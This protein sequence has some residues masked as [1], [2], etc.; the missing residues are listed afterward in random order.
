[1]PTNVLAVTGACFLTPRAAFEHVGGLSLTFPLNYNDID[2]CLKL[3][4]LGYR[5]V[6]TPEVRLFH[7]ESSSRVSGPVAKEELKALR[8]RWGSLLRRD[9]FYNPN[10]YAGTA[11]CLARVLPCER[12]LPSERFVS[13]VPD[14]LAET[15]AGSLTEGSPAA[16][17]KV[18][19]SDPKVPL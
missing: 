16:G 2:F 14:H 4:N 8:S 1:V 7:F 18:L 3:H 15:I 11:D 10:F 5:I 19:D 12:D 17:S 13:T 9:P 6:H